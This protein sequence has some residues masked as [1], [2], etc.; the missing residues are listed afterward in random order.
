MTS[1]RFRHTLRRL[2]CLFVVTVHP[3]GAAGQG[4]AD[5]EAAA[6]KGSFV[7][8][9]ARSRAVLASSPSADD[10]S[11]LRALFS[12]YPQIQDSGVTAVSV[13]IHAAQTEPDLLRAQ[14]QVLLFAKC[15]KFN[16]CA[17]E[18]LAGLQTRF[19]AVASAVILGTGIPLTFESNLLADWTASTGSSLDDALERRIYQNTM[20]NIAA[21]DPRD[22]PSVLMADRLF[23]Y[24][25]REPEAR[26][27]AL[28]TLEKVEWRRSDLDGPLREVYPELVKKR[29]GMAATAEPNTPGQKGGG[30][31]GSAIDFDTK[32]VEFGPWVRR[33][34]SQV[35]R[36]W[37]I[38]QAAMSLRGHVSV[39]FTVHKDGTITDVVVA[40]PSAVEGFNDAS[41]KAIAASNPATPLPPEY[42]D[43]KAFVTVTFYYNEAPPQK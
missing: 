5:V 31:F 3:L 14:S 18:A 8:A 10:V 39:S 17:A 26:E 37:F 33:F 19:A 43:E 1:I 13:F 21:R 32:G 35:R 9:F 22:T 24:L 7:Q 34:L 42:P 25:L 20:A 40:G 2:C 28:R 16:L 36:N 41:F 6:K 30:Q 23:R 11:T 4:V 29:G 12:K 15:V 27:E 38:P